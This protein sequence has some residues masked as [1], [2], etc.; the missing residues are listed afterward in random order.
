MTN[1]SHTKPIEIPEQRPLDPV[2]I[3]LLRDVKHACATLGA[4]FVVAG[5]TA[6]DI[7]MWHLH[8]IKAPVAT[9]DVDVAVCAISWDFHEA[10]IAR[11]VGTARFV[12]HPK[13]Q[14]KLL[15]RPDGEHSRSELDI[16]PFGP[17]EAN[18][19]E[20]RWPP[21]GET[22]MTVLGFQEAL[23]TAHVVD[24]GDGVAVPVVTLPA[25]VLLKLFAWKDRRLQKNTDVGDL[26]FVLRNYFDAG[27]AAFVYE[28]ALDLLQATGFDVKLAG[29]GLLGRQVRDIAR[30]HTLAALHALL[31][32][33][34]ARERLRRDIQ[35][36][37]ATLLAGF[38]D[39]GDALLDAFA[40][41]L[42][43][44]PDQR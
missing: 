4:Q 7:L 11:L 28:N 33:D 39:D 16:V 25:F 41:A 3:A 9:R 20:I 30:P 13:Q 15:F 1:T 43:K 6:R 23:D 42:L 19:G 36:R 35:A 14:Q 37:A 27:N 5:A 32:P 18:Q 8:G 29:A 26:L 22:V 21:D 31:Q 38:I 40:H 10:L 12:R 24:V 17:V 2:T 34:A 44:H